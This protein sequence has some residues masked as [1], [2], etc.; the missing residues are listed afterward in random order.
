MTVTDMLLNFRQALLAILPAVERVGIP[1]RRPD[2]YDDWDAIASAM[3]NAL[4]VEVF[5]WHVRSSSNGLFRMPGYDLLL[6]SY[7]GFCVLEVSHPAL[8]GGR[9]LF[10][11]FGTCD[12]PFDMIEVRR[13]SETGDPFDQELTQCSVEGAT[14]RLRLDPL[15]NAGETI[16]EIRIAE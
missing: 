15:S 8:Q 12:N 7:T 10:H 6:E 16:E 9:H 11:S 4:V 14:F 2:S 3:F 5:R 13:I 1:W